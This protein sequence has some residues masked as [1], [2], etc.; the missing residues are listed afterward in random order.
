MRS[1]DASQLRAHMTPRAE[2][3]ERFECFGGRCTVIVA[4]PD[5]AVARAAA[6]GAKARLLGWHDQFSR[7]TADSELS[8]VNADQRSV[9]PV[10]PLM[11]R[12]VAAALRAARDTGGL[13][14]PTLSDEIER[15][16]YDGHFEG[17]GV[18]L[19]QALRLAPPRA[20]ATPRE[21][22]AW[23]ELSVD[24]AAGV[25]RRP[26]G[27]RLDP[28]GIAKGVFAD[29]LA[30]ELAAHPAVVIDCAGDLRLGGSGAI[31]RSVHVE[32][33]FDGAVIHT[34]ELAA[35]GVATSGIGK[36]SWMLE[37][38]P[39]HHLLD[40]GTGR[41]AFTGIVQATALAPTGTEAEA[42]SKAALLSGL[43]AAPQWLVHGGV[44]VLDDGTHRVIG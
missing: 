35:G 3:V 38:R 19:E 14:D 2:H 5:A 37:G 1:I 24:V 25:V 9:V 41:P 13:V 32:S 15:A 23:R 26:P 17:A 34:Y 40:P 39:A 31:L 4:D 44:V 6:E 18:P 10:T 22:A 16:G 12:L 7:F 42:R 43:D 36:R 20:P 27:V 8:R 28:G 33:P 29:E 11:A 21:G 30:S